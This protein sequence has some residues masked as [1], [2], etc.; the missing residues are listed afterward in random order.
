MGESRATQ[1]LLRR[2]DQLGKFF[3]LSF[4]VLSPFSMG[5]QNSKC[6]TFLQLQFRDQKFLWKSWIHIYHGSYI[7]KLQ[8]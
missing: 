6:H 3:I 5:K 8:K 4:P 2:F 7:V 1:L